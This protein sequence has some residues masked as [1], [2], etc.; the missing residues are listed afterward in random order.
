M[1]HV[2]VMLKEQ[3]QQAILQLLRREGKIVARELSID[4]K[5]SEDTI[6]RD[7]NEM[8]ELG[9]L[10]R[11][12]GGALPKAPTEISYTSRERESRDAKAAIAEACISLLQPGQVIVID[13]GTTALRVAQGLPIDF[14]ATVVTNSV[15]VLETLSAHSAI[16]VIGLGGR[17]FKE[18]RC[19][20]GPQAVAGISA[21][22][23]DVCV[24]GLNGIHPEVGL[25]VLDY[26]S[27]PLKSAMLH[28][29]RQVIAVAASD[30][31]GTVATFLFGPITALTYLVTD[32]G[33]SEEALRP[34]HD[35]GIVVLTV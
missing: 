23:A 5:I 26:E 28:N 12:H 17:L 25:G 18:A 31:I 9:L 14:R 24:L 22:Y 34:F 11:V 32:K 7:L 10:H 8:G 15:P 16:E 19:L 1:H 27:V 4:L 2:F 29:A 30:K 13:S 21:I 20:L 6:R 33:A 3:R 35:A